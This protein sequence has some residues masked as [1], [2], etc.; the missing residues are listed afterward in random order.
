MPRERDETG[1]ALIVGPADVTAE[2]RAPTLNELFREF[3]VGNTDT[4]ANSNLRP[5]TLFG[6]EAGADWI[7]E[8]STLRLTAYRNSLDGLIA[9]VT[10]SS[11]PNSIVRQRQKRPRQ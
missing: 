11:S 10:L 9:N 3:R 8:R 5:E 4:L 7:G 1:R 2:V 6:A